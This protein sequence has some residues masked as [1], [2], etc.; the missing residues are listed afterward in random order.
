MG[1]FGKFRYRE[2]Y[3]K[4]F[5]V[6]SDGTH[7]RAS[8]YWKMVSH[9]SLFSF[10]KISPETL[11]QKIEKTPFQLITFIDHPKDFAMINMSNLKKVSRLLCFTTYHNIIKEKIEQ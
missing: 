11:I 6:F 9:V 2:F 1:L 8:D 5:K 4:R 7:Y 3:K 10:T